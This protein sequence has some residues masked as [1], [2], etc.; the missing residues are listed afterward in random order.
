MDKSREQFLEWFAREC[1]EVNN[2]DELSAQVIK[3]IAWSSWK[4]SRAAVEI[5]LPP[6]TEVHPL[7]P[8]AAKVFCEL[9]KNTVAECAKA[10][11][12]SGLRVKGE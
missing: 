4:S 11:R 1:E 3:M 12:A 8:S 7:G 9:H 10:I 5:E 2:S 6:T